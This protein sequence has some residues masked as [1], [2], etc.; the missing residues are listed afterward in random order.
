MTSFTSRLSMAAP[1]VALSLFGAGC[2][3][4]STTAKGPDAGVWKTTDRGQTPWV[5]KKALVAPGPKITNAVATYTILQ[6]AFDPQDHNVMYAATK[7][8]G[9]IYTLDGA[10]TWQQPNTLNTGRVNAVAIDPK[11]K[12]TLYAAS[13]NK[14]FKSDNTCGRDWQ[15]IFFD[16]RTEKSFTQLIIDWYNPTNLYAGTSDG[17][18]FRSKDSGV[19]WQVVKRVDGIS[20]TSL[21]MNQ[22]DSRT[23][24]AGTAGDGIWK[25]SD[26]GDSW[27][28]IKK[29]FGD[30]Y[31]DARRVTQVLI[32]PIDSETIYNVS[33]YGII[34]S[35]DGGET[36]KAL[37][38]TAPP[39]ALKINSLAIDPKNNKY[40][41]FTGV[42]TLQTSSDGGVTWT[43]KKLPTTQA[44]NV[45]VFDPVD[46]NVM[47]LGTT[48][49]PE[50]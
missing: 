44:G 15:Q 7:E 42:A 11:Q 18:I 39:G 19:S 1:L 32:D 6:L 31:R 4:S 43:P 24:Y 23:V 3:G 35:L 17:D 47:Y 34:K 27:I 20:I 21:V 13:G 38:L 29:Q 45:L 40:L 5:S 8:N 36:W 12:C 22:K 25:T 48:P 14:I 37:S 26:G 28:Q 41:A 30:E 50:K 16:P 46:S 2:F 49:P 10:N 9:M 33:K